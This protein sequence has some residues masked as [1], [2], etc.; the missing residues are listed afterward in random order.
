MGESAEEAV[1]REVLEE[2]GVEYEIDRLAFI[3]ENF[4]KGD[5][6]LEGKNCHEICFY[7][8]MKSRGTR[9]LNSNSYT[10]GV[11]EIMYW[12]PIEKLSNYRAYPK[13]FRE[14]LTN[15]RNEIEHIVTY[16]Y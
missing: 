1:K 16:E 5:G 3:H 15:L 9:N 6:S 8:L 4:F 14:K 11:K 13:F 7:F 12:I 10:G 2:I